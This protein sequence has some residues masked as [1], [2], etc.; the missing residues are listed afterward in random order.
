[1][2]QLSNN[3]KT[4]KQKSTGPKSNRFVSKN[5]K[6]LEERE[7]LKKRIVFGLT[8][9]ILFAISVLLIYS[10]AKTP[11]DIW[12]G[13]GNDKPESVFIDSL[14]GNIGG[15]GDIGNTGV[16]G[17][18]GSGSFEAWKIASTTNENLTHDDY[19]RTIKG[20]T[21]PSGDDG[22]EIWKTYNLQNSNRGETE[23]RKS[24]VGNKGGDGLSAY[25]VWRGSGA[26]NTDKK[27]EDFIEFLK[28]NSGNDG[29]TPYELWKEAKN[30]TEDTT[31]LDFH[32]LIKG[33]KGEDGLNAYEVWKSISPDNEDKTEKDFLESL[34]GDR[35]EKGGLAGFIPGEMRFFAGEMND[36]L[37]LPLDGRT[38]DRNKYPDLFRALK[39][40]KIP[41]YRGRIFAMA[42]DKNP[43]GSLSGSTTTLLN[44][45]YLP[46]VDITLDYSHVHTI[47]GVTN[48]TGSHKHEGIV[49]YNRSYFSGL[50]WTY[51]SNS[52]G[53]THSYDTSSDGEHA[54][55]M[56]GQF[57]SFEGFQT[58]GFNINGTGKQTS[59]DNRQKTYYSAVYIYTGIIN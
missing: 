7:K 38:F 41:D 13:L 31:L 30:N 8:G 14:K 43:Y 51:T 27:E 9:T 48:E 34:K 53:V 40:N 18:S 12:K 3:K 33:E 15:N 21:G 22:Y 17:N 11:Y 1:M 59:L 16:I 4:N 57:D 54:H 6:I 56:R 37:W 39:T 2:S 55:N 46:N 19:L 42:Y 5:I 36:P 25:E 47:T 29:L 45:S 28:G 23:F 58:R 20:T 35:G 26:D 52:D 24:L 50:S 32:N 10:N 44:E 49:S